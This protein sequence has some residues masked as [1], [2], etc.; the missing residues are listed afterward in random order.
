MKTSINMP[1]T[2]RWIAILAV[3]VMTCAPIAHADA[4]DD[5]ARDFWTWRATE[6]PV[7]LDDIPRL[8]RPA[9]WIPDWSPTALRSYR[10]Q[11]AAFE[12]R[13]NAID[14]S[15]WPVPRQVR[16]P[17]DRL[18]NRPRPLGVRLSRRMEE[19]SKFLSRS[20]PRSILSSASRPAALR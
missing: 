8:E 14:P 3:A 2:S 13:L 10:Q 11:V 7:S 12:R 17:P 18:R 1:R 6:M 4:F 5:L 9:G 19:E 20:N 15:H 16:L